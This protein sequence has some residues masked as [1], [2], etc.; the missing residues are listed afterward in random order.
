MEISIKPRAPFDF[1]ATA[2]FLRFTE[3]EAV[4]TFNENIYR[5]AIHLNN[6]LR[7]LKVSSSGT[8]SRPQ[9]AVT[10]EAHSAVT[11]SEKKMAEKIVRQIFSTDHDL[12]KF[13]AQVASDPLMSE[14]EVKCRGLHMARWP[15]LFEALTISILLQQISTTVALTFK[16]RLVEKFG[17]PFVA[18]DETY[19]AFPCAE[20]LAGASAN[21]LRILG[22]TN[23]KAASII[24]LARRVLN[25]ELD[26]SELAREDNEPLIA[27]LTQLRGVGRWTA[28]WALM[29]HFGRTN[30]FPAND[31]ALRA[32]VVK[33]YN[34]GVMM[35]EREIRELAN[36]LWGDWASYAAIY[37]LAGMRAHIISL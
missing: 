12:K 22:L 1:A 34:K 25:G 36:A 31:L 13:R 4:D 27:R 2:R 29:L 14:L 32:L 23:A 8:R 9:I 26:E 19:I 10:L 33:Y 17:E 30:V 5:R 3:A 20:A 28:E 6:R 35:S 37:F 18:G 15:S 21:D 11:I 7:L 24:E 16:R